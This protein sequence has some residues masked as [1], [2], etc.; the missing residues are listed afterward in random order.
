MYD[1]SFGVLN[2]RG[3]SHLCLLTY[4]EVILELLALSC[5]SRRAL[6]TPQ[7]AFPR[8]NEIK[9]IKRKIM[10]QTDGF[11]LLLLPHLEVLTFYS[12]NSK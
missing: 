4:L 11:F 8:F 10:R 7:C 1:S 3:C 6:L 5:T 9:V 2:V 12:Y